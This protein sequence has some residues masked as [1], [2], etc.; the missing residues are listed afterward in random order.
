[1]KRYFR[2]WPTAALSPR[3]VGT[4][5]LEDTTDQ[6][7][8]DRPARIVESDTQS[9]T[10]LLTPQKNGSGPCTMPLTFLRQA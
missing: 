2:N 1:M 8:V 4:A 6:I 5:A 9:Q 10:V 7:I 3:W